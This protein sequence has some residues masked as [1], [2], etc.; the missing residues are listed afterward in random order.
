MRELA[1]ANSNK[2]ALVD[3]EDYQKA[4]ETG[5]WTLQ[6]ERSREVA[7]KSICIGKKR[8]R[9][10]L[11]RVLQNADSR[12]MY[13]FEDGNGLNVQKSN[14][15]LVNGGAMEEDS[16]KFFV[17]KRCGIDKPHSD[18][19][20]RHVPENGKTYRR[21]QCRLCE[22]DIENT[23]RVRSPEKIRDANL[24]KLYGIGL[25]QWNAIFEKQG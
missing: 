15:F 10:Y 21:L 4:I 2:V 1:L 7:V 18:Y 12:F 20:Y 24:K 11:H 22:Q 9:V 6:H 13:K 5:P 25:D 3:D 14:F 23:T 19:R 17:C 8:T 16:G